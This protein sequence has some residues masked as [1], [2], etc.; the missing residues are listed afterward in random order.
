MKTPGK[1]R[2]V[3]S[4]TTLFARDA[5]TLSTGRSIKVERNNEAGYNKR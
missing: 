4:E 5:T 2:I 3:A 1:T